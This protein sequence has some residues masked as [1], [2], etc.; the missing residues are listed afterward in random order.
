MIRSTRAVSAFHTSS[1]LSV[2]A[3]GT[4]LEQRL[5]LDPDREPRHH[6]RPP[7]AACALL[8]VDG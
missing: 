6:R 3:S 4:S 1:S 7:L 5:G 8:D 2:S